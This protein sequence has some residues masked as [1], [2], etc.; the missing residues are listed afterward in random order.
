MKQ[1]EAVCSGIGPLQTLGDIIPAIDLH[2]STLYTHSHAHLL[3]VIL[4]C[5][6]V[7]HNGDP[8]T[9]LLTQH[10]QEAICVSAPH[11]A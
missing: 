3:I 1:S 8:G 4:W 7:I 10:I 9:Q 5:Q 11:R 6:E 2:P